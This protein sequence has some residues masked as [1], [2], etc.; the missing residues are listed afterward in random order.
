MSL[1][2]TLDVPIEDL[3]QDVLKQ[4]CDR[5]FTLATAESCTGGLLASVLTDIKGMSHAF[6][7]GFVTYSNDA[8]AELLDV[9]IELIERNGA[10][11]EPVAQAM[12]EG[13]IEHSR[14]DIAVAITG[15]ADDSSE[16]GPAGLVYLA[17]ARRGRPTKI[18]KKEFGDIGRERVRERSVAAGLELFRSQ[19]V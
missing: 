12:A 8:K 16:E 10:V 3:V 4:A 17:A 18:I 15:F 7:R 2:E 1:A 11:S 19:I 5:K 6:E 13:A 9:P 14:A